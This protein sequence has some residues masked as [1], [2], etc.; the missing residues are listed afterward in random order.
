MVVADGR[1]VAFGGD[2]GAY[3]ERDVLVLDGFDGL[4]VDDRCAI[5]G[6]LN[7]FAVGYLAYFHCVVEVLRVCVEESRHIF[8]NGNALCPKAVGE[9]GGAVVRPLAAEGGGGAG[10]RRACDEALGDD[11]AIVHRTSHLRLHGLFGGLPVDASLAEVAVG[12]YQLAG[13]LP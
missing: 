8:P 7:G 12:A 5:V 4:G 3:V 13:I 11:D 6:K 2:E 9:D 10:Y 1:A